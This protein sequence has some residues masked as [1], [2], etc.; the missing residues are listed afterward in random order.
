[1]AGLSAASML[2]R[3]GMQVVLF[4]KADKP[5]LAAHSRDFAEFVGGSGPLIGD[6]PSRMINQ[7]L[8]PGVCDIYAQAGV[9]TVKVDAD[10]SFYNVDGVCF[11]A[12]LPYVA[13]DALGAIARPSQAI[14]FNQLNQLRKVGMQWLA[15]HPSS[16]EN[17]ESF[18]QEQFGSQGNETFLRQF[19]FP[20]LSATVFTCPVE[21]LKRYPAALVLEALK[22]IA[23]GSALMR[24]KLGSSDAATKLLVDVNRLHF[25]TPVQQVHQEGSNVIVVSSSGRET[26]DHVIVATQANHVAGI[27]KDRDREM[28]LLGR[29]RYTDVPVTLHTDSSLLP[30][31][32]KDWATFNFDSQ[33]KQPCC[34]VW[35][36]RFHDQ[37]P[38]GI[39]VFQTIFQAQVDPDRVISRTVLQ[40][41]LVDEKTDE[42]WS[43]LDSLHSEKARRIWYVGSYAVPGVPLLESACQSSRAAVTRIME[44]IALPGS[45]KFS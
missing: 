42:L 20:A 30:Q 5:G 8:W 37:W 35:M 12:R 43:Q 18:L 31:R 44:S 22:K 33:P 27:V 1:M 39:D 3:R 4:E 17:F 13:S 28:E 32:K 24:T 23:G 19:L 9:A 29:F 14:I 26:F 38:A 40:R 6:V 16:G 10:Q 15:K 25:S 21:S 36:N 41:P 34:T 7:S 2:S 45:R 11:R